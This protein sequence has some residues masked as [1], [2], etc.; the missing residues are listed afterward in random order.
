MEEVCNKTVEDPKPLPVHD[1]PPYYKGLG[2]GPRSGLVYELEGIKVVSVPPLAVPCLPSSGV[3]IATDESDLSSYFMS[4]CD[5][6]LSP[7]D[8]GINL[9]GV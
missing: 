7:V 9:K 1:S 8:F 2:D 3:I 6:A 5:P 4:S